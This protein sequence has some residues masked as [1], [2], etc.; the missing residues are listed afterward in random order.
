MREDR[1][2]ILPQHQ[3]K[4]IEGETVALDDD[5]T[6]TISGYDGFTVL[7]KDQAREI[8]AMLLQWADTP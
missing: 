2:V 8:A 1:R 6:F 5:G 7:T 4:G 3:G